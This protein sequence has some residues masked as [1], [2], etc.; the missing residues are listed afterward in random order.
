MDPKD[1]IGGLMMVIFD[2]EVEAKLDPA[3]V[4]S[5]TIRSMSR[6]FRARTTKDPFLVDRFE[7]FVYGR[8]MAQCLLRAQ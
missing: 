1:S 2:E 4:S 6:R 8:E 3:D 7:L 5:R